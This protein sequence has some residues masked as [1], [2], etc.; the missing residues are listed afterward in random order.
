MNE[1]AVAS[2]P[3]PTPTPTPKVPKHRSPSYPAYDLETVLARA[4]DLHQLAGLHPAN[5]STVIRAWNYSAK[6][7]KGEARVLTLTQLGRELVHFDSDRTTDEWKQRAQAAAMSP[8]IHRELWRRYSGQLPTDRVLKDYMVLERRFSPSAADEVIAEFRRTLA[9]AGISADAGAS[10]DLPPEGEETEERDSNMASIVSPQP[11]P[12]AWSP[13]AP[14]ATA[15]RPKDPSAPLPVNVNLS[16]DG[17]ATLQV[18]AR[19][20]KTQWDQLMAVLNAMK[21]G[22]TT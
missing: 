9:F 16:D 15:A 14:A 10:I 18:S 21:P 20:T 12:P 8:E 4:K 6:S 1:T 17:W 5:V 11:P 7:S 3:T 2:T 22:L 13:A 19:L